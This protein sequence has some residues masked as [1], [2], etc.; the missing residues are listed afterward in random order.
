M[1]P[2]TTTSFP[3]DDDQPDWNEKINQHVDWDRIF[4]P[5]SEEIATTAAQFLPKLD[6]DSPAF[7]AALAG[8]GSSE[9]I[10]QLQA[11]LARTVDLPDVSQIFDRYAKDLPGLDFPQFVNPAGFHGFSSGDI[12][13]EITKLSAEITANLASD[14]TVLEINK[15]L[16]ESFKMPDSV[17]RSLGEALSANHTDTLDDAIRIAEDLPEVADSIQ[18]TIRDHPLQAAQFATSFSGKDP[19]ELREMSRIDRLGLISSTV[20]YVQQA[21]QTL[22]KAGE[23]DPLTTLM[24][25]TW[26]TFVYIVVILQ[27]EEATL[28]KRD[29]NLG[30]GQE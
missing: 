28:S 18:Q 10:R 8:W 13:P 2:P 25:L 21:G 19:V 16:A 3:D 4:K 6:Y 24:V 22:L 30:T 15:L 14:Q 5:L 1:T 12:S 27:S 9:E 29:Q 23:A 17:L 20:M 26:L 11:N 7:R